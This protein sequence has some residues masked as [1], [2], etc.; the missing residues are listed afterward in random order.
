MILRWNPRISEPAK[1]KTTKTKGESFGRQRQNYHG[2]REPTPRTVSISIPFLSSNLAVTVQDMPSIRQPQSP[3][4]SAHDHVLHEVPR[5]PLPWNQP[6]QLISQQRSAPVWMGLELIP[7]QG[8]LPWLLGVIGALLWIL[9]LEV[10]KVVTNDVDPP[11][12]WIVAKLTR[13]QLIS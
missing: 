3:F 13:S 6:L 12:C 5:L 2:F 9:L 11:C 1:K 8:P 4:H 7:A 10:V